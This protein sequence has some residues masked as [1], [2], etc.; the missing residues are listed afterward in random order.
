[1]LN[2]KLDIDSDKISKLK[3][4]SAY[5][6]RAGNR[7]FG[8]GLK[9]DIEFNNRAE[10]KS[11]IEILVAYAY[12]KNMATSLYMPAIYNRKYIQKD[13]TPRKLD[14]LKPGTNVEAFVGFS[15]TAYLFKYKTH[16]NFLPYYYSFFISKSNRMINSYE[17]MQSSDLF[18]TKARNAKSLV[19]YDIIQ[20]S[21]KKKW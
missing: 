5:S 8:R 17:E 12:T 21:V 14:L 1:V 7:S 6:M 11:P 3:I 13:T 4:H 18:Y 10:L 19:G 20:K 9:I 15:E 2:I 16:S